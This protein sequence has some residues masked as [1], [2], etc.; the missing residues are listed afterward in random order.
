MDHQGLLRHEKKKNPVNV[1]T[2][3]MIMMMNDG[4]HRRGVKQIFDRSEKA[5]QSYTETLYKALFCMATKPVSH[6]EPLE[7]NINMNLYKDPVRTTQ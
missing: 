2:T 1:T 6:N 5:W 7:T 4:D 3:I